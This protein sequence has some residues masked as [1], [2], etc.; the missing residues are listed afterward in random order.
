M[1]EKFFV[2][3]TTVDRIRSSWIGGAIEQYVEWLDERGYA[4]RSVFL[5]VPLLVRFGECARE[6]GASG[7]ESLP[8]HVEHSTRFPHRVWLIAATPKEARF[9]KSEP[10]GTANA[11][12]DG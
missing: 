12:S 4:S 11:G 3:P 5:R 10:H 9:L 1:L 2:R 7:W 8:E 6:R